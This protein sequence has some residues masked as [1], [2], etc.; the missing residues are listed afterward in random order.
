MYSKAYSAA[1]QGIEACLVKV[2]AD[3]CEG[4]PV[5][6]MVGYL[7]QE[8]R[9]AKERVRVALKNSGLRLPPKHI[10]INLSPADL[11]KEGTAYDLSIAAAILAAFGHIPEKHLKE[12]LF[13]GELSLDGRLCQVRG[14]LPAAYM[15]KKEGFKKIIVPNSNVMEGAAVEGIEVIGISRI[16]ELLDYFQGKKKI[17]PGKVDIRQLAEEKR[18]NAP[19]D[20]SDIC[21]QE[22]LKRAVEIAV[23][24]MHHILITGPPGVGKTMA[25]KRIPGIMPDMSFE[26]S[27][28]ISK[29]YSIAGMLPEDIPY[30]VERPFR[31]PHH[32]ITPAALAG[33]GRRARAGEVSL[34]SGGV[35][36]LDELPEFKKG[37]LELLRQPLE[38]KKIT[39][40]RNGISYCYPA[41][42]M[43]VGAMNP[44]QCG[45]YPDRNKCRCSIR[46]IQKYQQRL[47]GPLLDRIDLCGEASAFLGD[48]LGSAGTG[49]TSRQIKERI[50]CAREV[51]YR[52]YKKEA[53]YF[54]GSLTPGIMKRYC[55][56]S[57]EAEM[58]LK[59]FLEREEVSARG[60]H[61]II[62][63]ARTIAD[64]DE[65]EQIQEKHITESIFYRMQ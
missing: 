16:M 2:E 23:A 55:G 47:S 4:L 59:E 62:K 60:Y 41:D 36:F 37:T 52:R 17:Q 22:S 3:I 31:A 63:V 27:M 20:F 42:F 11:Y 12:T 34:A 51:Q 38:D 24:G 7:S 6:S 5:F 30:M 53:I 46:E 13:I 45:Y 58:I 48:K 9:E 8:A 54:N 39:I 26:E 64:L 32:T 33:G 1:I 29:V 40:S 56:M 19:E 43:L 61:K 25:A 18:K 14:T 65:K 10:T 57:Q 44:C 15:A 49:E 28:E 21:G 35:L 50:S